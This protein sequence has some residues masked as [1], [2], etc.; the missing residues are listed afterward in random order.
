MDTQELIKNFI[1][2]GAAKPLKHP[3]NQALL[4]VSGLLLYMLIFMFFDGLRPNLMQKLENPIF[5]FEL[6]VLFL[7]CVSA[8][9]AAFCLSR[10]DSY[11]MPWVKY[12]P[13]PLFLI[14]AVTAFISAGDEIAFRKLL[15]SMT[16]GQF[17]C[18][19]HILFFSGLPG[20]VIFV[21]IRMG[22]S[23]RYYWAGFMAT[24]SVTSL[25]YL[26]MRL[27]EDTDNPAHLIVWH[28]LPIILLCLVGMVAGR[29]ALKW[30]S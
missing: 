4:W 6:F 25:A 2:E 30:R 3:L 23:I 15:D 8:S 5:I 18:P 12:L 20:V 22:A 7:L 11:Q 1:E 9:L 10:P 24:L 27:V 29:Y 13:L 21:L 16:L 28:A 17:D 19:W 14:W 26:F